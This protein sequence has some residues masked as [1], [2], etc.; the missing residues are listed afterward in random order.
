MGQNMTAMFEIRDTANQDEIINFVASFNSE[1][2]KQFT[3]F[4]GL[5]HDA[6][7]SK[8]YQNGR[9]NFFLY[10]AGFLSGYG[11]LQEKWVPNSHI[12]NF[13]VVISPSN[14]NFGNGRL[15]MEYMINQAKQMGLKKI[16]GGCFEDNH[17][18]AKLYRHLGFT[19]E[20]V[21]LNEELYDGKYR[22]LFS[23]AKYLYHGGS[24]ENWGTDPEF[25]KRRF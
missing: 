5:S 24:G 21:F 19:C 1:T 22:H 6:I 2:K 4:N 23:L 15:L 16:W 10:I 20:G 11:F 14:Q 3:H 17:I 7:I 25:W 13:G 9:H 8:I 12:A 18:A